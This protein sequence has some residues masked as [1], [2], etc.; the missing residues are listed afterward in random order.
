MKK[1]IFVF[2]P[3]IFL[4]T[5]LSISVSAGSSSS[6]PYY[7]SGDL[8]TNSA[9]SSWFDR[10]IDVYG[11]RLLV[12][13]K[14][15]GQE[16]VPD[17]WAKKTAQTFKLLMDRDAFGIDSGAQRQMIKI[18]RGETGWHTGRPAGQ[19]IAYGSG[20]SYS[21]NPLS[22]QGRL[23]YAGLE[24]LGDSMALDDMVWYKNVDSRFTGDDDIT[25]ILEHVLHT[26][27]RFGVRGAIQGSSEDLNMEVEIDDITQTALYLAMREAYDNGV[28]DIDGY[29]GD[30]N[31]TEA[32][33][34]MLK[35][36]QYLLT[37]GMWG[38]GSVF[39]ENGS[40]SPE[41]ND[42]SITA[43]GV[44]KNNPLGHTLFETYFSP[45]ISKPSISAL[46]LIFQNDDQGV[47][48]YQSSSGQVQAGYLDIDGNGQYDALT[49]GLL[50]LRGMF[51][52]DGSALITGT[53]ASDAAYTES[54][55]IESRIV[56]LGYLA[57][58]D[59][60]GTIDA[61]TDGLLTLRYLF[62]LEGE[63][64]IT[65]VVASDATRTTAVEIE[66]HLKTLMPAL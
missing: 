45:V 59:G 5:L 63:T 27:H 43:E 19:R 50:L 55:D 38:F 23:S 28:F 64:L 42:N 2:L 35:E 52:L 10:S 14:V 56:T 30:I 61:L 62:G 15:G 21:P 58:I 34:M 48:G 3:V 33:P 37:F 16:A 51:G 65:G 41:W 1:I 4:V 44:R 24:A 49:D 40:L 6:E 36:Y 54:V 47:S 26:L 9:I 7:S 13:G 17:E 18:L 53:I 11:V 8:V 32:W 12:A 29:G 66:A 22:D 60:N 46:R 31:N 20:S 25:E 57:D 39:W